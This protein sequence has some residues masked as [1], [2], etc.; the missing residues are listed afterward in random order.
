MKINTAPR[1]MSNLIHLQI[2]KTSFG[3]VNMVLVNGQ[4]LPHRSCYLQPACVTYDNKAWETNNAATQLS[5]QM[6]CN[7]RCAR[8]IPTGRQ[9]HSP[10]LNTQ[11]KESD[12]GTNKAKHA[13]QLRHEEV[14]LQHRLAGGTQAVALAASLVR[15]LQIQQGQRHLCRHGQTLQR[16]CCRVL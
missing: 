7:K 14:L 6:I 15:C 12:H 1:I 8:M 3:D 10:V 11:R 13:G 4:T 16:G 5:T 9:A 2:D